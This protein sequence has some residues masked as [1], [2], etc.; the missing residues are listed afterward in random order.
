MLLCPFLLTKT[1][2][3]KT[4]CNGEMDCVPQETFNKTAARRPRGMMDTAWKKS[5]AKIHGKSLRDQ[6]FLMFFG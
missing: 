1:K 3:A 4:G 5:Q 6:L 2:D